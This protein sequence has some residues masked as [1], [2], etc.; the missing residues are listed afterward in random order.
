NRPALRQNNLSLAQ[1]AMISSGLC[2]L[3]I[4]LSFMPKSKADPGS[5]RRE[6]SGHVFK[7]QVSANY[8]YI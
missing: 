4:P 5:L 1:L 6:R 3:A 2:F 8:F 7:A